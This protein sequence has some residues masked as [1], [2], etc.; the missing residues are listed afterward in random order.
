MADAEQVREGPVALVVGTR[1]GLFMARSDAEREHWI[2]DGP[3]VA[4][5]EIQS[6]FLDPRDTRFGYAAAHHPV[7]GIHI[8]ATDD[9]G[10]HWEAL[11]EVPRHGMDDQDPRNLRMVWCLAPGAA[12][13]PETVYA[14]IEPPGLFVSRDSGRTWT[15]L[16]A[17]NRH[18]TRDLWHPA[19]GGLAVHSV[20]VDPNDP[21][22]I[23][24]ALSAGGV[25][26][27]V[28]G[29]A[30]FD[31]AN[32]GVRAPY[33]PQR[34]P[35]AGHCVH[36]L[37]MHPANTQRLYQQSHNGTY[38]SSDGG[39]NWR[40]ITN[41]LPS[42]F[43][44]ALATDPRDPNTVYT[45]PEASSQFRATVD[46]RLR[47]YRSRDAGGSWTELTQGLPQRNV[48]VTILRDGMD[49]DD[50]HPNGVYFGTSSG[51]LFASRDDGRS[52]S[53]IAGFLPG[54]LSVKACRAPEE[55]T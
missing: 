38:V 48:F 45:I 20:Q 16:E 40:E 43:G 29:G 50:R 27:S 15:P 1:K 6:A 24:L 35:E 23:Q 51:H 10:R 46:G 7:W 9:G 54:I 4:G 12:S 32:S 3:H 11:P 28:D 30:S 13:E 26:R 36:R 52:W 34:N 18:P 25:Y 33:L 14:A 21:Q 41:G 5:Y 42:D 37:L 17:F 19:K 55:E 47:V 2:L 49:A 39:E 8:Y 22:R 53:L 44:Y 31:P